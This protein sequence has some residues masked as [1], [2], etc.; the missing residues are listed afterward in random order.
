MLP[1]ESL[2][3]EP[4]PD[5]PAGGAR[6]SQQSGARPLDSSM[7]CGY[8]KQQIASV[9]EMPLH[10]VASDQ[11]LLELGIDSIIAAE[12][13]RWLERRTGQ[14]LP[15]TVFFDYGTL[16]RL[17][18]A[19]VEEHGVRQWNE[20]VT[21]RSEEGEEDDN[22]CAVAAQGS[23]ACDAPDDR[24][25]WD[26]QQSAVRNA[27]HRRSGAEDQ[28][29]SHETI[30]QMPREAIAIVGYSGRFP[31]APDLGRFWQ[32]LIEG[33]DAVD[34][35]PPE[36]WLV[37]RFYDPD[38]RARGKSYSKWAALL[39]DIDRFDASVFHISR[40][41]AEQMDPQQRVLLEVAWE[42]LEHAGYAG[43]GF[44]GSRTGVFVG[45][46]ASEYL[47]R[48]VRQPQRMDLHV[49]TGNATSVVANRLSFTFDW[50]G[51]CV[52]IDTACSSSLVALHMAMRSL[53]QG[54][55][56]HALVGATQAG[57]APSHFQV[58]S[59][60]GA[61]SPTGR[62]RTFDARA[63]GYV[64]GEGA[65]AVLLK[66]LRQA[67]A[68]GDT[69][70]G[71]LL[72][73]AVNHG[74]RSAGLTVPNSQRQADVIREALNDAGIEAETL[75]YI[76][77]HGTG[78]VLG[79]P[80][81]IEGLRRALSDVK[82]RQ[83]CGI[84]SVKSNIGHLEP[85]AGLAGLIKVLL[86]LRAGELPPTLHV[87]QPNR[88]LALEN[89]PLYIVD[90]RQPWSR[91]SHPRRAGISSFGFG[92]TNAHVI[93]E[94]PPQPNT[95][96]RTLD[97]ERPW[98]LLVLS[99]MTPTAL[100]QLADRFA[101]HLRG[102]PGTPIGD[103]CYT[104][105]VGRRRMPCRVAMLVDQTKALIE[106]LERIGREGIAA[107]SI[108]GA[109]G[110]TN[111][112]VPQPMC[113]VA[114]SQPIESV[115]ADGGEPLR[116]E[117]VLRQHIDA[118]S[119]DVCV[120]IYRWCPTP[121]VRRAI[122]QRLRALRTSDAGSAGQSLAYL[123][124]GQLSSRSSLLD[125]TRSW[126]PRQWHRA[127]RVLSE[128]ALSDATI[129]WMAFESGYDRRRVEL[130]TYPF[131]RQ[132][133]WIVDPETE[134]LNAAEAAATGKPAQ[135]STRS[136]AQRCADVSP[137]LS[138]SSASPSS[139][140]IT[141]ADASL[142]RTWLHHVTWK[143][144]PGSGS[145]GKETPAKSAAAGSCK[146]QADDSGPSQKGIGQH[147]VRSG[148][149]PSAGH[150]WVVCSGSSD[151]DTK[152]TEAILAA[153]KRRG[154]D[155]I[156]LRSGA[157]FAGLANGR[158]TVDLQQLSDQWKRLL[159]ALEQKGQR[160]VGVV[161][162]GSG[163]FAGKGS[164]GVACGAVQTPT[165]S[166]FAG[167]ENAMRWMQLMI[168]HASS[169][170]DLWITTWDRPT[171]P[172]NRPALQPDSAAIWSL[173]R[174]A[175]LEHP[176]WRLGCF[177][178]E[179]PATEQHYRDAAEA[180]VDR[181][182]D[183]RPEAIRSVVQLGRQ[184]WHMGVEP[185]GETN[186]RPRRL[187]WPENGVY[188]VTGGFGAL[189][190][191]AAE[192][193][194]GLGARNLVLVGRRGLPP[195]SQ[196]EACL[197]SISREDPLSQRI[198]IVRR[199][200]QQGID[201][202]PVAADVADGQAMRRI[203]E[204]LRQQGRTVRGV[205]HTAG[206]LRDSLL[207]HAWSEQL[208]ELMR[209]KVEGLAT[210][211]QC[212]AN[213]PL[214]FL[215]VYSSLAALTGN[216][217]QACYAA[218]NAWMDA[219]CMGLRQHGVP[220]ISLH[221]GPWQ[222]AG[223][224]ASDAHANRFRS[225][226]LRLIP[227]DVGRRLLA[228]VI[229]AQPHG[230]GIYAGTADSANQ[231]HASDGSARAGDFSRLPIGDPRRTVLEYTEQ[232]VPLDRRGV[233][234]ADSTDTAPRQR[235]HGPGTT[236]TEAASPA[237]TAHAS[238]A[239]DA[240]AGDPSASTGTAAS[241]K[242]DISRSSG[243]SSNTDS[244]STGSLKQA[245]EAGGEAT[246]SD[247]PLPTSRAGK[248][249][250]GTHIEP[251][252]GSAA[253]LEPRPDESAIRDIVRTVFAEVL[254]VDAETLADDRPFHELGIDS[255]MAE[256]AAA[257]IQVRL[258]KT[259]LTATQL[260]EHPTIAQLSRFLAQQKPTTFSTSALANDAETLPGSTTAEPTVAKPAVAEP[261]MVE[262]TTERPPTSESTAVDSGAEQ[263]AAETS[264]TGVPSGAG[265]ASQ[266]ARSEELAS[267]SSSSAADVA[268][269]DRD[270]DA[271][272]VGGDCSDGA[273]SRQRASAE[274]KA[275]VKP[276]G[277]HTI[278]EAI[279]GAVL[280]AGDR[281]DR[282]IAIVGYAG[283]FPGAPSAEALWQQLCAGRCLW[284]PMPKERWQRLR[285]RNPEAA[286]ELDP[287][288]LVGAYL[289]P[290][291]DF[292]PERFGITPT[293]ARQMDP[294]QRLFLEV[295]NE[296]LEVAGYAGERLHGSRTG[297]FV[298]SGGQDYLVEVPAT[299][300][301]EH[302]AAGGTSATLPAR[303]A[304][305]LDL[306]G[307]CLPVDTACS[308]SLVALHLAV[309]SLRRGE[310][311]QAVVGAVHLY[312]RLTSLVALRNTGAVSQHGACR[313]FDAAADGFVPGEG[314]AAVL[315]KPLSAAVSDGDT[316]YGV[317]RGS[318]VN[319]DGRTSGLTAPSPAAQRDVILAAWR[320]AA[321]DPTTISYIEA[322]GTGT[323]LPAWRA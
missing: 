247:M 120:A 255:L 212:L 191:E 132:R 188:L 105:H 322:H 124:D 197:R 301:S 246:S 236:A 308:S 249:Q 108:A 43:D 41:E 118:L 125:V 156:G 293:E 37:E 275:Q 134:S 52:A 258:R 142:L 137:S 152:F 88:A 147:L 186:W 184:A 148:T 40:R 75:S 265:T 71:V 160:P 93:V 317:I 261:T 12:L 56:D 32:N 51:P 272:A 26:A 62:C 163:G 8:L 220:A 42:A 70:H 202:R 46:M 155:G 222:A 208:R 302:S 31:K 104:V 242:N 282:D 55:C 192:T 185:L 15:Q 187:V 1:E 64:L 214:D 101:R 201:V 259:H 243:S 35:V 307:P 182:L 14:S 291:A 320:D 73:S 141:P 169:R 167:L 287:Q 143:P 240:V 99:A 279:G 183:R 50:T 68:D 65:A 128:L 303:L 131:Q 225:A 298:A 237:A 113:V 223:M 232:F 224:A 203:V 260:F 85:A 110:T 264:K 91:R 162:V 146:T 289:E 53:R 100:Q 144:M 276:I 58:M 194:V 121:S 250:S 45:A 84:G 172:A 158:A 23:R 305:W 198:R 164:V 38:R 252:S 114:S 179:P 238:S 295:A 22:N 221:W 206:V 323:R 119:A 253:S 219:I 217:G 161:L 86:S 297:V 311:Q 44:A 190:I 39:D 166:D 36:R 139:T 72:G 168:E 181:L 154:V 29:R 82:Q 81:E 195:E 262:P 83:W 205:V 87:E 170:P 233:P 193:L 175:R 284:G 129:D 150:T 245:A 133:Y 215:V 207:R 228:A 263:R 288:M 21:P 97:N 48:L 17:A 2:P 74:G 130:P 199:W 28:E 66:P 294:R 230:W 218:A 315:L 20:G 138:S 266:S 5:R 278:Q 231:A 60:L 274:R 140:T 304:Y 111:L 103:I 300:L 106:L 269:S 281:D 229:Q 98:H 153:L 277:A 96:S 200:R 102:Q 316:I 109:T 210:L 173:V 171:Q 47:Q 189:G 77:A 116:S 107:G 165:S 136:S 290:V 285:A 57:L 95:T 135:P 283:R 257:E 24:A 216:V 312:L 34:E 30:G 11:P 280:P 9:L 27:D 286:R 227:S 157:G 117:A 226:G 251:A 63:D 3:E 299:E 204:S 67:L 78:T 319:N 174:A 79:D 314:V 151:R 159:A 92:G 321:L 16:D 309:E 270:G 90:R 149:Q 6:Y 178:L 122:E 313:P 267:P 115:S 69:I 292:A 234:S 61:L 33:V 13:T 18:K 254:R 213:D 7:L 177:S 176:D 271:T 180:L 244:T 4:L 273:M 306:R 10:R 310:C 296:A 19:L 49:G 59:R 89:T 248:A 127:L 126:T 235:P 209:P 239:P 94:E 211:T 256:E 318:A 145:L 76:E 54:E 80:I 241:D 196:W 268:R 112:A 123:F 25:R